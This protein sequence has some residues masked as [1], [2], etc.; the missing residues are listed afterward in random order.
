[1]HGR[2]GRGQRRPGQPSPMVAHPG[3]EL[4]KQVFLSSA[5]RVKKKRTGQLML[6]TWKNVDFDL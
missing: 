5:K 6:I 4:G 2:H 1:M 3:Q